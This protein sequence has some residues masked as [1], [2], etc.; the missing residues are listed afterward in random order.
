MKDAP[1]QKFAAAEVVDFGL[2][3]TM[4]DYTEGGKTVRKNP[5]QNFTEGVVRMLD[6]SE[7]RGF[8]AMPPGNPDKVYFVRDA[9]ANIESIRATKIF[10]FIQNRP[11]GEVELIAY[12]GYLSPLLVRGKNFTM[13]ENLLPTTQKKP[14]FL[15]GFANDLA[16]G[17]SEPL[18]QKAAQ[19]AAEAEAKKRIEA[20]QGLA[21]VAGGAAVAGADAAQQMDA[22]MSGIS[23]GGGFKK[24]FVIRNTRTS[25]EIVV[26]EDNIKEVL[27]PVVD[28]C[29]TT[30]ELSKGKKKD[31]LNFKKLEDLVRTLDSCF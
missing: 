8:V 25:F 2:R 3:Y 14:G 23:F 26:S 10:G 20:G 7:R 6:G 31:L 4:D 18:S 29:K 11:T 5:V 30:R 16:N 1:K 17:L 21:D 27:T 22:A 19:R 9:E 24:E 28:G 13:F 15:A 12:N